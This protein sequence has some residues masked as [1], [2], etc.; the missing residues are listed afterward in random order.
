MVVEK[1]SP[2]EG[3]TDKLVINTWNNQHIF[4]EYEARKLAKILN[5]AFGE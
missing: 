5:E 4:D 2:G 3:K 1:Y